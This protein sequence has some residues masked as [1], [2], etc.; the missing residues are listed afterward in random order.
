[1]YNKYSVILNVV[2]NVAYENS[3]DRKDNSKTLQ[4]QI[5]RFFQASKKERKWPKN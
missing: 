2:L 3:F 4:Q 1:M 5:C